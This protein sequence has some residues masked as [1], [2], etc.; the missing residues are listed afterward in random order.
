MKIVLD[1]LI[2]GFALVVLSPLILLL[3]LLIRIESSGGGLFIQERVGLRRKIFLCY[4]LRTMAAGTVQAGSHEVSASAVTRVGKILRA[5]KLDEVPQLWNVVKGDMS[6]VG[7]RPCLPMQV[8]L[9]EER[10]S[11]GV[12]EVLPG[13]TG[14]AQVEGIDMSDPVRLAE[15]DADYIREHSFRL[16]MEIL[17]RTVLGKGSGDRVRETQDN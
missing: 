3:I 8:E 17:F 14:L 16:D 15:K 10:K 2:S 7:P 11:R 13:I 1:R 5:T 4:K 6:L 9:I 12:L